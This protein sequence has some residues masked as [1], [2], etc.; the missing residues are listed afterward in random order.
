MKNITVVGLGYIGMP[1]VV[2]LSNKGHKVFGYDISEEVI[3]KI[4][5]GKYPESVNT[6]KIKPFNLTTIPDE[7][8]PKSNFII[9]CVPTPITKDKKPDTSYIQSAA[10]TISKHLKKDQ[11]VIFESSTYPG[12]TEELI[13][14]ILEESGLKEGKDFGLIYSPER[15]DP[16]S[17]T[18]TLE[19]LPKLIAGNNKEHLEKVRNLY[20]EII[21]EV[22]TTDN[23][24]VAEITKLFENTFRQ[25]NI[26]LANELALLCEKLGI[27]VYNVIKL[28][29]T[30]PAGFMPH[31]PGPGVGGDCIPT[32]PLYLYWEGI[33]HG[34]DFSL[35]KIAD[36]VNSKMPLHIIDLI[37][38][39]VDKTKPILILGISYKPNVASIK[40]SAAEVILQGLK[41]K[42]WKTSYFDPKVKK[43]KEFF[44]EIDLENAIDKANTVVILVAHDYFKNYDLKNMLR[45]KV[46][47]DAC[48]FF[49]VNVGKKYIGLGKGN[50]ELPFLN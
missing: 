23:I 18:Y 49:Q 44:S 14:P 40:N 12:T 21:N 24:K 11:I 22:I 29:A 34:F 48:N 47:I 2:A 5:E 30:K 19:N 35:I 27:N 20:S 7:C 4:S 38:K 17:K 25:V 41:S 13:K 16:G 26:A 28:A 45:D 33:K 36:Q 46:I 32:V 15:L 37:E 39:N 10:K 9:I 31:Y 8:L 43:T 6:T 50:I 1:L 3:K 42:G